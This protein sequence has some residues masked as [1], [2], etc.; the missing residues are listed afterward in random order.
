ML[1]G[2]TGHGSSMALSTELATPGVSPST[3]VRIGTPVKGIIECGTGY[4]SHELYDVKVTVVEVARGSKASALL[5]PLA[6][7]SSS[8]LEYLAARIKFE[9]SARG[10]PGDC[11]HELKAAQFI[12]YTLDG[13]EY[14]ATLT[15]PPAP[16]LKGRICAGKLFE[17]WV[18]F[19]VAVDDNK[20]VTMFDAGVGG[21]EGVEHGGNIW[22]RLY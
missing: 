8:N 20:P 9:Y 16:E 12:A 14:K 6:S 17:G 1:P 2:C 15:Q 7:P 19:E 21:L 3:A 10:A 18:L 4:T 11:C 13:Q 22:L 5:S